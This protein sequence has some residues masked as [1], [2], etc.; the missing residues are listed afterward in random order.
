MSE[1]EWWKGGPIASSA[2]LTVGALQKAY[3]KIQEMGYISPT[4]YLDPMVAHLY[5]CFLVRAYW[6]REYR[7]FRMFR[8]SCEM[9]WLNGHL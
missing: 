8:K 1:F 6:K 7:E 2:V 4:F 3:N 5:R 9:G